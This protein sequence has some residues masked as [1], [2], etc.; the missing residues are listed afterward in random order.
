MPADTAFPDWPRPAR[1]GSVVVVG[2]LVAD[3]VLELS[4][5]LVVGGQQRVA[6]TASAGGA[7][8]NVTAGL[9][10]A[11]VPARLAG[12]AGADPLTDG[13]LDGL[14]SRGVELAVVRRGRSPL[15]TVLVHPDGERTMLTD[16]GEGGLEVGD[17]Q[18]EWVAGA[19]VVHLDGYDLLRSPRALAAAASL[20]HEAG[21]PVSADV[22][23]ATRIA[24]HGVEAYVEL[25]AA[26]AADVLFCNA[27]EAVVL[28]LT[29]ELPAWAP[30]LVLVHEGPRPTRMVTRGGVAEVPVAPLAAVR[31]TTGC[32]DAFAAGVLAGWRAGSPVRTAVEAGHAAA[33][34][35][36]GVVGA[37]PPS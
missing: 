16:R 34:L 3:Q 2:K 35:V 28:G 27:G 1:S 8:A 19:A 22:A 26:L 4:G 7:A 18:P 23:A 31:D 21:V 32:G 12:W 15:T 10:R 29:E 25:L 30:E 37:Q 13:L 33:A 9:A 5:P 6:R 24:K 36:A 20:A 17:V 11:G 14:A